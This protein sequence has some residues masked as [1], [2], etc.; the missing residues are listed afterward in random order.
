M[1]GEGWTRPVADQ[2]GGVQD[3]ERLREQA[4]SACGPIADRWGL[5]VLA[6]QGIAGWLTTLTALRPQPAVPEPVAQPDADHGQRERM[7]D[8]LVAMT[9]AHT[10]P[11][12]SA[13]HA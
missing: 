1:S 9:R 5:A 10:S 12:R 3:Y 11:G 6:R 2:V 8:I 4:L 13:P 7:I